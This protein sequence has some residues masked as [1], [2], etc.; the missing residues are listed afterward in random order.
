MTAT[1]IRQSEALPDEY[2]AAPAGLSVAAKALD[3]DLIWQRIE[4]YTA[5]RFTPR[6]VMWIVV[7]G[8]E[9]EPPLTPATVATSEF[10]TG[11]AWETATPDPSPLG[12]FLLRGYGPY[13]FTGTVGGGDVPAAILEAY[14]R[15]AEYM[16]AKPGTAGASSEFRTIPGVM[17]SKTIRSESWMALALQ[18]S[19]AADLLRPYRKV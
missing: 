8:G 19:G 10:W 5:Y 7:G 11:G 1:T 17:T 9:W 14:R 6:S 2:P 18:N 12:G 3:R 4:G 16:A 15:L 13:R